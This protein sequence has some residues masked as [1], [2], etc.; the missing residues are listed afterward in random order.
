MARAILLIGVMTMTL[1]ACGS[2]ESQM[3][4]LESVVRWVQVGHSIL[5]SL[6]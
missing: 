3:K 5:K 2:Y 4:T 6:D 1:S